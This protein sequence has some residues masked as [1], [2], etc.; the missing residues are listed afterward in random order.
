MKRRVTLE[1]C[2][3]L[4]STGDLMVP[5]ADILSADDLAQ[6]VIRVWMVFTVR[7]VQLRPIKIRM[8]VAD[9]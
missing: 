3:G 4:E 5:T 2:T 7:P 6:P 8:M 9:V 1:D